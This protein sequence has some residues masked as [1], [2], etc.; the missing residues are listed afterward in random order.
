MADHRGM[1]RLPR[2]SAGFWNLST[3]HLAGVVFAAA[4]LALTPL[5][6][7]NQA[8]SPKRSP[9]SSSIQPSVPP[10]VP[11]PTPEASDGMTAAPA[12]NAD[13]ATVALPSGTVVASSA[14]SLESDGIV[15]DIVDDGGGEQTYPPEIASDPTLE[16]YLS[17]A[18]SVFLR[19]RWGPAPGT[20]WRYHVACDQ[21]AVPPAWVEFSSVW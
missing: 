16:P 12:V 9:E 21:I 13:I 11:S 2:S 4:A 5:I 1:A 3:R 15:V 18:G 17:V 20:V 6:L 10:F 7:L 19:V 14:T 8:S